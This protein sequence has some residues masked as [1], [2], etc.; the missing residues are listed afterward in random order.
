MS[1]EGW[2]I[3][4]GAGTS[5]LHRLGGGGGRSEKSSEGGVSSGVFGSGAGGR[6]RTQEKDVIFSSSE[7]S[8]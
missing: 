8:A 7:R 3:D 2:S 4:G 5:P 6:G 1:E